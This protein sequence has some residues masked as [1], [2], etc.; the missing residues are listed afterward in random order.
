M[1][2]AKYLQSLVRDPRVKQS[3]TGLAN[4]LHREG[5]LYAF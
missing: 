2:V 1:L 4:L 5:M 3:R